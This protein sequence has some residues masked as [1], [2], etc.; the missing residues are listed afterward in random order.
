VEERLGS[1]SWRESL[2]EILHPNPLNLEFKRLG[3][4][5]KILTR[6]RFCDFEGNPKNEFKGAPEEAPE[7]LIPWFSHQKRTSQE[8][9]VVCGHWA[10]LGLRL[11]P[12]LMAIDTGCVWGKSLTAVRLE[13]GCVFQE[14]FSDSK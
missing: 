2:R 10:A 1:S 13:D 14:P 11:Q 4:T 6:I 9:T 8:I 7:G 5:V 3:E 12:G